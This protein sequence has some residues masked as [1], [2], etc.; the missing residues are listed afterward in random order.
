MQINFLVADFDFEEGAMRGRIS[1]YFKTAA[2]Y[3]GVSVTTVRL[4]VG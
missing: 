3:L 2:G 1:Q 4:S